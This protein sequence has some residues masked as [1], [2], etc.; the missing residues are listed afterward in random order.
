MNDNRNISDELEQLSGQVMHC[1]TLLRA[2]LLL[3]LES[4]T[5]DREKLAASL[6]IIADR[7]KGK[8]GDESYCSP[9][10]LLTATIHLNDLI[11][12]IVLPG[13]TIQ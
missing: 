3:L 8:A 10:T 9:K 2:L 11:K 12:T 5:L 1:E 13:E 7:W 4:G 6:G